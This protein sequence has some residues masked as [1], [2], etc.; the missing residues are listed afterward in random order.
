MTNIEITKLQ[1]VID[2][3]ESDKE[4]YQSLIEEKDRTI[5][6]LN[7]TVEKKSNEINEYSQEN[8]QLRQTIGKYTNS[9]ISKNNSFI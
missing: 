5:K 9:T 4:N 2:Q 6:L 8:T 7:Q 1:N 3:L